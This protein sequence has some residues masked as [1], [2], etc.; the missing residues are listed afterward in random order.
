MA[1]KADTL[2]N[3]A[4]LYTRIEKFIT[5]NSYPPSVREVCEML[6]T[7]S[8]YVGHYYLSLMKA[9]GWLDWKPGQSRTLQ[10]K[11]RP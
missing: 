6:G 4:E 7:P 10:L 1:H 2:E 5:V 11:G 8:S 3:A 9:K